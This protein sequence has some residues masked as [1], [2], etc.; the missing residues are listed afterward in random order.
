MTDLKTLRLAS[1]QLTAPLL[2]QFLVYQRTLVAELDRSG[3]A[4]DW[5]GRFAFA[6]SHALKVSGLDAVTYGKVKALVG[7]W[8]AKQGS[9]VQVRDRLAQAQ[10]RIAAAKASGT[11]V[12]RKDELLV[13]RAIKEL[14]GLERKGE[15]E[16]RY[17]AQAVE[18]LLGQGAEVVR[19]HREVGRREGCSV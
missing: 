5:S 3:A 9:L 1:I 13:E 16:E 2:D 11:P 15:V 4:T 12:D 6:H 10:A 18:L 8:C 14:P 19:L 17:G 7:D